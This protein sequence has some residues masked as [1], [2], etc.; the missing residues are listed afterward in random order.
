MQQWVHNKFQEHKSAPDNFHYQ[1]Q[2]HN[3][4]NQY[5]SFAERK[6]KMTQ[7]SRTKISFTRTK[8]LM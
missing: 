5:T 2:F 7:V 1:N 4:K 8:E 6:I 3:C